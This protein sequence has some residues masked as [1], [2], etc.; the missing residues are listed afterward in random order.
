MTNDTPKRR[1]PKPGSGKGATTVSYRVSIRLDQIDFWDGLPNRSAF[2]Q[3][4]I[5]EAI[6]EKE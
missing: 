2:V 3:A 5:D 1:G 4:A 6:K